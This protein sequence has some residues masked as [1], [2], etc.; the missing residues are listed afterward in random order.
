MDSSTDVLSWLALMG[1]AI[2]V[3]SWIKLKFPNLPVW[4]VQPISVLVMV[5]TV[6]LGSS[7]QVVQTQEFNGVTLE[8]M[9]ALTKF[10]LG[11]VLGW[12]NS[13]IVSVIKTVDPKSETRL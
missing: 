12:T 1:A 6:F 2:S 13:F 11:F 8:S 10:G 5:L 3:V 7:M 9:T 4:S